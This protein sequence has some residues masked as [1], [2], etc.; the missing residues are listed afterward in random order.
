MML[1]KKQWTFPLLLALVAIF[2]S[3]ALFGILYLYDNKYTAPAAQPQNGVITLTQK[4]FTE[5]PIQYLINGWEI[6]PEVL[7]TPQDFSTK[8][9]D[10][11]YTF[12]GQYGGMEA[13]DSTRSPHGSAT[14]RLTLMLPE[15]AAEY[16]LKLPEIFSAY[17]L[18]LNG[19]MIAASGNPSPSDYEPNIRE[20]IISFHG[21]GQTEL[22]IAVTDYSG[23]Y[24]GIVYPPAFGYLQAVVTAHDA[25]LFLHAI[26]VTAALIGAIAA[27]YFGKRGKNNTGV[28]CCLLGLSLAWISGYPLLHN[29]FNVTYFPLYP[30]ELIL[31]Y[32][33]LLLIVILQN[34]LYNICYKWTWLFTLPCTA[35]IVAAAIYSI[36]APYLSAASMNAFSNFTAII[37]FY[38]AGYLIATSAYA[39]TKHKKHSSFILCA[40]LMFATALIFD[41]IF[42]LYE[43]IVGGWFTEIGGLILVIAFECAL[44]VELANAYRFRLAFESEHKQMEHRISMQKE[45]YKQLSEQV[46]KTRIASHDLRHHIHMLHELS[47]KG[48]LNEINRYLEN[49][50]PH[51]TEHEVNTF[52][53]HPTADAVLLH[54]ASRAKLANALYDVSM[55]IPRSFCFPDDEL[56]ILLSNLLENAVEAV[57]KQKIGKKFIY[58]RGETADNKL[59]LV[60]DNSF[61]GTLREKDEFFYSSKHSGLG[62]G[63]RSIRA[64]VNRYNGSISFSSDNNV[65]RVSILIPLAK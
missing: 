22:I 15:Q 33:M 49:Y 24:S 65:F 39:I 36:G 8:R 12:I 50:A 42:P 55:S 60:V 26:I 64:I 25:R 31:F 16:A 53:D 18:Y 28:L 4:D 40:S 5:T 38:T 63:I 46:E 29:F 56:C 11:Q 30:L 47:N 17:H 62:I 6:Y 14:Y 54:Y 13:G 23:I 7:L 27:L 19:S 57:A 43:P 32:A 41:R 59:R 48:S 9:T 58:L 37:K 35:G 52:T 51:I 20:R 10:T 45:H 34:R 44:W 2:A 1:K 3:S 61:S 21:S